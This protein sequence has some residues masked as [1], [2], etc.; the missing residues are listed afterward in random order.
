MKILK[1]LLLFF[2]IV[3][4]SCITNTYVYADNSYYYVGGFPLGF[5]LS[6]KGAL[7]IG[8][9]EV[10][11]DDDIYLP[12]KDAGIKP[13]D[14]IIS[15]NGTNIQTAADIDSVLEKYK[16]GGIIAE[17]LSGDN[18]SIVN[19][20][21]KMDLSGEYKIGVLIRDYLSGIGTVTIIDQK[22]NYCSLGHPILDEEGNL[23]GVGGGNVYE[24]K[25][26]GVTKGSRGY[27]GEL[28]G[29]I[30]RNN[31]LGY[32]TENSSV[33]LIGK[34]D[35]NK[36]SSS[37]E[38]YELGSPQPGSAE[39]YTTISGFS[40]KKYKIAIVKVDENEKN[41]KNM[42]IKIT[43]EKLIKY[44]GGIVQ[45][46]SGSPIVQNNKIVGAVT[47]V[48]LNDSLRGY[49]ISIDKMYCKITN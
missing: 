20:F 38:K 47:H 19:I 2:L 21:P 7:V 29:S 39:I 3:I 34:L 27:A 32:V 35:I 14:Y 26:V 43:D 28:K 16:N 22:G 1:K 15:L 8:L 30:I 46:M 25:I 17:I 48:F 41:N 10:I 23:L 13:G 49:A 11:C 40:P 4:L 12:A 33:G 9:T 5:D 31:K 45:G 6:G 44:A 24:C 42:V 36:L 37:T 18:K